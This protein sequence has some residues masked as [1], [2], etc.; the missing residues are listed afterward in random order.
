MKFLLYLYCFRQILNRVGLEDPVPSEGT[1]INKSPGEKSSK[2]L[3]KQYFE[4]LDPEQVKQ[5]VEIYKF[6]FEAFGY[7]PKEFLH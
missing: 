7:D 2:D 6:D 5:L 4:T 3:T 1:R